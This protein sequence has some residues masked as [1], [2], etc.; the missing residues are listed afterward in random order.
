MISV[1]IPTINDTELGD[2]LKLLRE[3]TE[4]SSDVEIIIINDGGDIPNCDLQNGKLI[5]NGKNWG[6]GYSFDRGA[7]HAKGD[8]III[9]G[10]DV[11]P[12]HGWHK[13]V[14]NTVSN[15]PGILGCA[16]SVGLN[17]KRMNME[18][19]GCFRR[20][21][22]DLLF[23]VSEDD[24]PEK[25]ALRGKEGGYTA[26]FKGK[27]KHGKENDSPYEIPCLMGAFYFTSKDYY[28]KLHGWDTEEGN[29]WCGH[30]YW[31]GLEPHISLKSWLH[32]GGCMLYPDIEAGHV[33]ARLRRSRRYRHG[34]RS[35]EWMWWNSLWT[36]ETM[37]LDADLRKKLYDF[38]I[39]ELNLGKAKKMIKDHYSEV[40]RIR[41]RNRQEFKY[42]HT[43]F[44]DRFGYEFNF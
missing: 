19:K 15:N 8:I 32:G 23:T 5:N 26:L 40:E 11:R 27:W 28:F 44:T 35:A 18:D 34:L 38:P 24:L 10:S 2:T 12:R 9:M 41:E 33:F 37:I 4:Y 31:S 7:K 42:D 39:P 3:T 1:L 13:K 29:P 43:I 36:L 21:G 6:V 16:V 25:S 17:P 14:F 22:A 20:Y 30:R